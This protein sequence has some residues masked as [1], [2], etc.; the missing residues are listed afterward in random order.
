MTAGTFIGKQSFKRAV[1]LY[2]PIF[3]FES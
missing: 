1:F 2:R 3:N